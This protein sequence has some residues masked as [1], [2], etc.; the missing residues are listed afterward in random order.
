[1]IAETPPE[2]SSDSIS[3]LTS[4]RLEAIKVYIKSAKQFRKSI[5]DRESNEKS[6]Q[7]ELME[8][9]L[10]FELS[11]TSK[12][13]QEIEIEVKVQVIGLNDDELE[14]RTSGIPDVKRRYEKLRSS[15]CLHNLL[16][17]PPLLK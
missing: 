9:S 10:E 11:N 14:R 7:K 3:K 5:R 2:T 4:L 6:T 17:K 13:I 15:I 16:T 1:M 12:F 8:R